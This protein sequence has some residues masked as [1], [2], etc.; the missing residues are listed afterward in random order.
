MGLFVRAITGASAS[1][2][3]RIAPM[4]MPPMPLRHGEG[5]A[6]EHGN[7]RAVF[8]CYCYALSVAAGIERKRLVR[9]MKVRGAIAGAA[10][11]ML[12]VWLSNMAKIRRLLL[13]LLCLECCRCCRTKDTGPS[14]ESPRRHCRCHR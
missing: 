9:R 14:P 8:C 11:S 7:E 10:L 6:V 13:L 12:Q 2:K 5:Q 3:E 1:R 4:Q